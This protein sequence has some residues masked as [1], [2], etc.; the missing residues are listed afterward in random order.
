MS[1]IALIADVHM[2]VPNKQDDIMYALDVVKMYAKCNEI[3][4]IVLLGDLFHNRRI[5][6]IDGMSLMYNYLR[7]CKDEGINFIAFPGNH[8]MFLKYSWS[9][10]SLSALRDVATIIDEVSLIEI[11][12]SRFWIIPFVYSEEAYMDILRRVEKEYKEDDVLL[13]HIGV[14]SATLNKCFLL[15]NWSFVD[16]SKSKFDKVF[17]GHFHVPQKVGENVWYPGSLI[18]F[19]FDEGDCQHGF[20]IYD[21]DTREHY[22]E[23]VVKLGK[24]YFPDR[25]SPP[26]FYTLL[27]ELLAEKTE[28]HID[29]NV[30]RVAM[31]K[32]YTQK[33]KE[34]IRLQ[35]MDMGAVRV[36]FMDITDKPEI[37][38]SNHTR[39]LPIEELLLS[40]IKN[41]KNKGDLSEKVLI[42]TDHELRQIGDELYNRD[43][44]AET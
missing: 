23:D 26:G 14:R 35:L 22:Y 1:K 31:T 25:Q 29:G 24:D 5:I 34:D 43:K 40:W 12:G 16:F 36:S 11:F 19:K 7:G 6:T 15:H 37:L 17:T 8:D 21:V 32:E 2:D 18:P 27:D 30:V 41:D 38:E 44:V 9:I 13:T 28:E 42:R 39:A 33:Q 3:T 10:N 4:D 20:I